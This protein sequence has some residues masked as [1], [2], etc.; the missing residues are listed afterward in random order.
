MKGIFRGEVEDLGDLKND[1]LLGVK[2]GK[3]CL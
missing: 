2:K 3:E 1:R